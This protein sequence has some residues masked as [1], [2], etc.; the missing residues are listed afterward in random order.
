M[1]AGVSVIFKHIAGTYKAVYSSDLDSW[2]KVQPQFLEWA[3]AEGAKLSPM[4]QVRDWI[5]LN[6][7]AVKGWFAQQSDIIQQA[8]AMEST[9]NNYSGYL[10]LG[11]ACALSG[12]II[13]KMLQGIKAEKRLKSSGKLG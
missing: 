5:L 11:V 3:Q 10:M 1:L 13:V 12:L 6:K 7:D 9:W 4:V 2:V 8:K